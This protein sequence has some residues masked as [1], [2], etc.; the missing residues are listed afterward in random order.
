MTRLSGLGGGELPDDYLPEDFERPENY[1]DQL[2]PVL[3]LD[4]EEMLMEETGVDPNAPR[5]IFSPMR[6][7]LTR[8]DL[9]GHD[10]IR[11]CA[12]TILKKVPYLCQNYDSSRFSD[13]TRVSKGVPEVV[14]EYRKAVNVA[15][16]LIEDFGFDGG[17]TPTGVCLFDMLLG[18]EPH[19]YADDAHLIVDIQ[20]TLLPS[21]P[22]TA[23]QQLA[24]L[25]SRREMVEGLPEKRASNRLEIGLHELYL[26]MLERMIASTETALDFGEFHYERLK[27]E[28]NMRGQGQIG[29][30]GRAN[31]VDRLIC[32]WVEKPVPEISGRLASPA[33]PVAAP[34]PVIQQAPVD[35]TQI[36][37]IAAGVILALKQQ[38]MFDPPQGAAPVGQTA[39]VAA[40]PPVEASKP[41]ANP[42]SNTAQG[43][44][45]KPVEEKKA[46][47]DGKSKDAPPASPTPPGSNPRGGGNQGQNRR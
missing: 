24:L 30:K 38:G 22:K 23:R 1:D 35:A 25:E 9:C 14:T 21:R 37:A 16:G 39:P 2:S 44:Q 13:D 29:Y 12:I 33:V 40:A 32:A 18:L 8:H 3:D 42:Q 34:A 47:E 5:F 15:N 27:D 26:S 45:Q 20:K 10:V 46:T 36:G 4:V 11:A 6:D 28:L 41:D 31:K 43:S 19:R 17:T 7:L